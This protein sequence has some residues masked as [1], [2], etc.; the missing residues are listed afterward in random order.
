VRLWPRRREESEP[1]PPEPE[2]GLRLERETVAPGEVLRGSVV[3]PSGET[4][5]VGVTLRLH[6]RSV[7]CD[8]IVAEHS[9]P[10][11]RREQLDGTVAHRF[12][13]PV[14]SD[15][16]PSCASPH[17]GLAWTV[18]V[19]GPSIEDEPLVREVKVAAAAPEPAAA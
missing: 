9:D 16:L 5:A 19:A 11:P 12:A 1:G 6:E 8:V 2:L 13:I 18:D 10:E 15:A 17:G 3:L 14:P 4:T 7:D